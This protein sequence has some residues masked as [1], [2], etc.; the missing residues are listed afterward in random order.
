MVTDPASRPPDYSCHYSTIKF[1]HVKDAQGGAYA[2]YKAYLTHE[3]PQQ[4][5]KELLLAMLQL[6]CHKHHLYY[7]VRGQRGA[8]TVT[9]GLCSTAL[10]WR[11]LQVEN[12][13]GDD[14][15]VQPSCVALLL[16]PQ[17]VLPRCGNT[18]LPCP[19]LSSQGLHAYKGPVN[20]RSTCKDPNVLIAVL[21]SKVQS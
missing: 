16:V 17:S 8:S 9:R 12:H 21:G 4:L 13:A 20:Q 19:M 14:L 2:V 11:L 18:L 3:E 7:S 1:D 15:L 6:C 5:H 10:G